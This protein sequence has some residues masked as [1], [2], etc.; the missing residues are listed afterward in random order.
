MSK[1]IPQY[2]QVYT[3]LDDDY[4]M[5]SRS[6]AYKKIRHE[7]VMVQI[8]SEVASLTN[9]NDLLD[10]D[11]TYL[12]DGDTLVWNATSEV[13]EC[14]PPSGGG[15]SALADLTDVDLTGINDGDLLAYDLGTTTWLPVGDV[16][17]GT[18][19][20]TYLVKWTGTNTI[21]YG[22]IT[23]SGSAIGIGT[24]TYTYTLNL[25]GQSSRS[26]GMVRNTTSNTAGNGLNIYAGGATSGAT[27]KDGGSYNVYAG[28]STGTGTSTYNVYTSPAGSSGTADNTQT[29]KLSING[30]GTSEFTTSTANNK[31]KIGS[32]LVTI[33][34]ASTGI[35]IVMSRSS[36][37]SYI[38]HGGIYTSATTNRLNFGGFNAGFNFI[39]N[40][41]SDTVPCVVIG[42][43]SENS[44]SNLWIGTG[45][46]GTYMYHFV[47]TWTNS[48]SSISSYTE[49]AGTNT[50]AAQSI[51]AKYINNIV[52][53]TSTGTNY[54]LQIN[55]SGHTTTNLNVALQ[56][57]S[58][59][60]LIGT[61]TTTDFHL[62]FGN[63]VDRTIGITRSTSSTIGRKLTINAGS[64]ALAGTD[65]TGGNVEIVTGTGT[66]LYGADFVV[67][68]S[69]PGTTG[70]SDNTPTD[71]FIVKGNGNVGI[72]TTSPS[73]VALLDITSTKM[74]VVFPRMTSTQASAITPIEGLML[75]STDT[76]G[77]F[78]SVGYWQYRSGAWAAM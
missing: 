30:A 10:V 32:N 76:N 2:P 28:I 58:G 39:K 36:D 53:N 70:S 7:D 13:W 67:K 37:G 38:V 6:N 73:T 45:A 5:I 68:T 14:L 54:G 74:G 34:S 63:S 17:R 77:T 72:G 57:V 19:L 33:L 42:A 20:N 26:I 24:T 61:G 75:F 29:L 56:L 55:T 25:S 46:S 59:G 44:G 4:L 49:V 35:G 23:D 8:A 41:A 50:N 69:T 62:T 21:D 47:R 52:T 43:S 16:A 27:N 48:G 60:L 12:S 18:G 65:L 11:T 9:L 78:T 1:S 31:L 71:K 64:A 66:G 51:V 40:P 22:I 3:L 15:A